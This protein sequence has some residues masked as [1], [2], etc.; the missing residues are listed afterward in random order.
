[1]SNKTCEGIFIG[2]FIS[3]RQKRKTVQMS[4]KKMFKHVARVS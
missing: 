1:M 2:V 3:I 4:I